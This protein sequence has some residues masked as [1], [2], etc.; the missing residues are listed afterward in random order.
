MRIGFVAF[1]SALAFGRSPNPIAP[2]ATAET[3]MKRLLV[4]NLIESG[5]MAAVFSRCNRTIPFLQ[6]VHKPL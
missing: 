2:P 5:S 4:V 3:L 1:S 6:Y